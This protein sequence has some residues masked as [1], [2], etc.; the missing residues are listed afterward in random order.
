MRK[1][2]KLLLIDN[3]DSFTYNIVQYLGEL[4]TETTV[5]RN[6]KFAMSDVEE[7][8]PE[9]IV[10][11]PGPGTPAQAGNTMEVIRRFGS[12]IPILGVCLGHQAIAQV[13]GGSVVPAGQVMHGRTSA[14]QH[15]GSGIFAGIPSPVTVTRYHSLVTEDIPDELSVNAWT[16]DDGQRV[17][18]GLRHREYPVWGVQFHPESILSEQG[19]E[20]LDN[21]LALR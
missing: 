4:G 8:A 10:I 14:V 16:E 1:H 17:V 13:Y 19:R 15:D 7:L 20:M 3:Y 6:D 2:E 5:W 9:A 21:F 18:M 12:R 11:S